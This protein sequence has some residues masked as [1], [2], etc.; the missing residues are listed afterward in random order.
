MVNFIDRPFVLALFDERLLLR[1]I[2]PIIEKV[3]DAIIPKF[4]ICSN[5]FDELEF[6]K[7]H[8]EHISNAGKTEQ[9]KQD[10][11]VKFEGS[12][13]QAINSFKQLKA[14]EQK[15]IEQQVK[16]KVLMLAELLASDTFILLPS[17]DGGVPGIASVSGV[18]SI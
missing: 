11:K 2:E 5:T 12:V 1:K 9:Q 18:E 3:A 17:D 10:F 7:K 13:K 14:E 8:L 15:L 6:Y 4:E 16:A